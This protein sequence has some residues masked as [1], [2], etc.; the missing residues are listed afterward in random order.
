MTATNSHLNSFQ[1]KEPQVAKRR[2]SNN[3]PRATNAANSVSVDRA[4]SPSS[5]SSETAPRPKFVLTEEQ[6]KANHIQSEQK[7]REKIREQYDKL[8]DLTPGMEGQGRSEGR[9]LEEAAKFA[10]V[11]KEERDKLIAE[12]EAL[13]GIVDPSLKKY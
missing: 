7:R 5:G 8:A 2:D 4:D 6:K 11:L 1:P 10:Q 9:V 12:I 13:G 3:K